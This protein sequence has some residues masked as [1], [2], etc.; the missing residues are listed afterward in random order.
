MLGAS[1]ARAQGEVRAAATCRGPEALSN[2]LVLPSTP[3]ESRSPPGRLAQPRGRQALRAEL[4]GGVHGA[5]R[6]T[7][8]SRK[9]WACAGRITG[10]ALGGAP[11][12]VTCR[13]RRSRVGFTIEVLSPSNLNPKAPTAQAAQGPPYDEARQCV[14]TSAPT[15]LVPQP[16]FPDDTFEIHTFGRVPLAFGQSVQQQL[17]SHGVAHASSTDSASGRSTTPG[18]SPSTCALA[19]RPAS[20]TSSATAG[21]PTPLSGC[22][23]GTRPGRGVAD[24]RPRATPRVL[25]RVGA[26][27][28]GLSVVRGLRRG[29][30]DL[31]GRS[32]QDADHVPRS[33]CSTPTTR[34]TRTTPRSGGTGCGGSSSSW[35]TRV[36]SSGPAGPGR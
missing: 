6:C 29:M 1:P 9:R 16:A 10:S 35:T 2:H 11:S 26:E 4:R 7:F 22:R 20:P 32:A 27:Q 33:R 23:S 31:E 25:L 8:K 12:A 19:G 17:V 13:S 14:D 18:V 21:A 24:R 28:P 15:Q 3:R 30:G 5:G 34:S 36:S